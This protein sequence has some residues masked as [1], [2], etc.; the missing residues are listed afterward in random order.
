MGGRRSR[1]ERKARKTSKE[2]AGAE[3]SQIRVPAFVRPTFRLAPAFFAN[4]ILSPLWDFCELQLP[5]LSAIDDFTHQ[6]TFQYY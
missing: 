4:Q 5:C 6:W 3:S 2:A 1:S